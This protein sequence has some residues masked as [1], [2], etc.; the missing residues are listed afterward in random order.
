[1][2]IEEDQKISIRKINYFIFPHRESHCPRL[3]DCALIHTV[4]WQ[5]QLQ[6]FQ[7]SPPVLQP[8]HWPETTVSTALSLGYDSTLI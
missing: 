7:L 4:T 5:L 2:K 8:L 1:M 3:E 6:M